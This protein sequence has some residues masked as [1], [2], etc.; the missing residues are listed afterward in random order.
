MTFNVTECGNFHEGWGL[1]RVLLP[2]CSRL[3]VVIPIVKEHLHFVY[4][5]RHVA[6]FASDQGIER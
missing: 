2:N 1:H 3:I 6:R 5:V 4:D